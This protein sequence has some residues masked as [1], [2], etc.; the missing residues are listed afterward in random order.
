[1]AHYLHNAPEYMESMFGL[2]KAGLVPVNTN[3]R[4]S[5]DE[6][7]YLWSNADAVAVVFHATF[8]E[9]VERVR[10]R[11]PLVRT[12][13]H[14]DD[15]GGGPCPAWATPYEEVAASA[16]GRTRAAVGSQRRRPVHPLHRR[17]HR[18]AQGR[19]VAPGRRRSPASTPRPGAPSHPS[20][21]TRRWP[22]GS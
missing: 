10:A 8:T 13:L 14:V 22:P 9:T 2:Y 6:L 1:M 20:R 18:H 7:V 15:G 21:R 16:A 11:V 19:D 17:H 3:Y 5:D 12:W 4:Y